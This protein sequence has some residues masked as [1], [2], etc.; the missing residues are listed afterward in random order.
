MV[1]GSH[2]GEGYSESAEAKLAFQQRGWLRRLWQRSP[3]SEPL[4]STPNL[5]A[6]PALGTSLAR[7]HADDVRNVRFSNT[8]FRAGY[9]QGEV[10]DFLDRVESHLRADGADRSA[11]AITDEAVV[12]QR[13][14]GTKF[15]AGYDQDEVDDFLDR[16]VTE[17]RRRR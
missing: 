14:R 9:D 10:D 15:R 4:T 6:T 11:R 2:S 1:P 13:F 17:L 12:N 7:L 5:P 16:I 3:L 8:K